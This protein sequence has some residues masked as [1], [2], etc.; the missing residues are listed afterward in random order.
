[1]GNVCPKN[2]GHNFEAGV[3]VVSCEIRSAL[4]K[5][6]GF[7]LAKQSFLEECVETDGYHA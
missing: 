1:M 2:Q 7:S 5:A 3:A 6:D 4:L